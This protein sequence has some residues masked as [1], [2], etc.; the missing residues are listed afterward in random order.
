MSKSKGWIGVD[1]DGTAA[2][3]NHG[4]GIA[5]IGAPIPK[6]IERIRTWI[7]QGIEVRIVTARVASCNQTNEGGIVDNPA[8]A[9]AQRKMIEE[10]TVVHIG[11]RLRVTAQKDF[12]MVQLWDDRAVQ[13]ISNTGISVEIH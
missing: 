3:Y 12:Q 11:K 5:G 13:V 10:W 7:A 9:E 8:F 1:L 6:M 2:I 4:D